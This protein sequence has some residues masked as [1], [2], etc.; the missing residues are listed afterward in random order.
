MLTAQAMPLVALEQFFDSLCTGA[1]GLLRGIGK[2]SIG[3]P[4]NLI[5]HYLVS[6][7][8]CLI[9]GFHYVWK[10][11]GLWGGIAAGLMVVSLIEYGYLLT[12]D[13]HVACEEAEA[14]NTAG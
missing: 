13:W 8:L 1:H 5:G 12:I 6:L 4:V 10:L 14:R 7:P 2:Q 11:A 9:L 3:G